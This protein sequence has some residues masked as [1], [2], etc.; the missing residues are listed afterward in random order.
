MRKCGASTTLWR[1]LR[2]ALRRPRRLIGVAALAFVMYE[3]FSF[4]GV[5]KVFKDLLQSV[6]DWTRAAKEAWLAS[7]EAVR[8]WAEWLNGWLEWAQLLMPLE[9]CTSMITLMGCPSGPR[10]KK[11]PFISPLGRTS[12]AITGHGL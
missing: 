5:V 7:S 6:V 1:T 12:L 4:L 8:D 11:P 9:S 2:W 3:L 10:L